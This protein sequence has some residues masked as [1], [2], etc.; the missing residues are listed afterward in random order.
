MGSGRGPN[1]GRLVQTPRVP[2]FP[3]MRAGQLLAVLMRAPLSY[4]VERQRGSHRHLVAE[5]RAPV[6]FSFHDKATVP[7]GLVRSILV[8]TV[9]LTVEEAHRLL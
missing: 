6:L 8:K 3:S 7:P 9:G 4:T 2:D 1:V 5:G